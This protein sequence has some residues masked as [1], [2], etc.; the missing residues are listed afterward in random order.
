MN[1]RRII[2]SLTTLVDGRYPAP[3]HPGGKWSL[4][5]V[6]GSWRDMFNVVYT[7]PEGNQSTERVMATEYSSADREEQLTWPRIRRAVL[8]VYDN[9]LHEEKELLEL[10]WRR[11]RGTKYITK[12]NNDD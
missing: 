7:D 5:K 9:I 12:E 4:K 1:F 10:Q 2:A 8:S 11:S 3:I 6:E